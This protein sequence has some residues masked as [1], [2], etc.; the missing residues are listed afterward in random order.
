MA[1]IPAKNLTQIGKPDSSAILE[2]LKRQTQLSINCVQIGVIQAFDAATQLATIKISM[3][4][5]KDVLEDGTRTLQEYPLLLECPVVVLFG[6]NDFLSM[7]IAVGDNCVVLFND[8]EIDQWLYHGDGQ[9]PVTARL[10]DISDAFA[11]VGIRSL[12]RSIASYLANGIRLSHNNGNSKMDLKDG[13]IDTVATL[14]LQHG[15]MEVTGDLTVDGN[16]LVKEDLEVQGDALVDGGLTVLGVTHGNAGTLTIDAN[17]T[18]TSGHTLTAP[19]VNS[20]NGA[21]GSFNFVTVVN[22]IVT[23]GS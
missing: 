21:T 6:G 2:G 4:Q 10:H 13:L 22:G 1:D 15:N 18:L 19:V 14:F 8:R 20:G 3:K 23:G 12:T 9:S 16:G 11:L 17:A 5:V 7:P